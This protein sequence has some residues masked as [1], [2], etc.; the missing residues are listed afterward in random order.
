MFISRDNRRTIGVVKRG[1]RKGEKD[2]NRTKIGILTITIVLLITIG[3]GAWNMPGN[4]KKYEQDMNGTVNTTVHNTTMQNSNVIPL[5]KPP[6]L[7]E[8]EP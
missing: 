4:S 5:E 1:I 2:M 6:F 7:K 3:I 8:V